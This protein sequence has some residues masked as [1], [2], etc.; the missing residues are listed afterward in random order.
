[1]MAA[2]KIRP[3]AIKVGIQLQTFAAR[4][5][6]LG[7]NSEPE[8]SVLA[9]ARLPALHHPACGGLFVIASAMSLC[10]A[11]VASMA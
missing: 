7:K 11:H 5:R 3:A 9:L 1:M 10:A 8:G 4:G 6:R 2:T